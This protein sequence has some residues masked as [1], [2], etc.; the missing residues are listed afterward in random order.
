MN[1]TGIWRL[2]RRYV[3]IFDPTLFGILLLLTLVSLVTMFSAANDSMSRLMIHTRNL[4]V[5]VLLTWV[6][7]LLRPRHLM[8][9]A[10]PLYVLGLALLIGVEL[11][12]VSA[13]GARRWLDLGAFRIQP[14]E[15]MKMALPLLLAWFFHHSGR[16]SGQNRYLIAMLLAVV[17]VALIGRQ[18][19][20]GTAILVASAGAFT[21]YF[22]GLGWR[23]ILGGLVIFISALPLLWINMKPYQQQRVLTML[24]PTSDPLGKGFHIIQSTIAVGS[25]GLDGKGWLHGT[26]AHLDFVPE[27]STDFIFSV[28]AEEFGLIGTAV[29]LLLY[30]ALISR[31]LM[32]AAGART[33]FARLL[34]AATTMTFFTYA[35]VNIGMV[36]GILPVVGVPLP[37]MSYGGTALVTLGLGTGMLMCVARENSLYRQNPNHR[38][39]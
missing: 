34:A 36:I 29:L 30:L 31:G 11:V 39:H 7:T 32:I 12:G 8:H 1:L 20:L 19:D 35:F 33:T 38:Y 3:L 37:L 24:D 6:V 18:P 27:R 25:G 23:V 14:S 26:Q 21:I 2:L 10:I 17:P 4:G 13:K 28:Y 15:L 9:A 16:L 5:A 22:A